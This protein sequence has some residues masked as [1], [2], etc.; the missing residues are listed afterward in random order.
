MRQP[1]RLQLL[2]LVGHVVSVSGLPTFIDR[3]PGRGA[4]IVE[5]RRF[6]VYRDSV[7]FR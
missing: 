6:A 4:G 3:P 5:G 1:E 2:E 7:G